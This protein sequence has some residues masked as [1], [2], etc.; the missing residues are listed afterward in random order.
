M[1][2]REEAVRNDGMLIGIA[3]LSLL[4]GM[5]FSPW[6]D[7]A[8]PVAVSMAPFLSGVPIV[9]FY[10][11]S[12]L[13]SALTLVLAGVPAAIFERATGRTRSDATSLGVWL[14]ACGILAIPA[15][16]GMAGIR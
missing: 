8:L 9:L 12:L 10:V 3:A 1:Q 15:I 6:F 13:L 14:V 2:D 5:H 7:R 16:M 4:N 11:T